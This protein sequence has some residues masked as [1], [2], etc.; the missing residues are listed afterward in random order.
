MFDKKGE[1][2]AGEVGEAFYFGLDEGRQGYAVDL[3]GGVNDA[4]FYCCV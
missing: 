1:S 3:S 4:H 2:R